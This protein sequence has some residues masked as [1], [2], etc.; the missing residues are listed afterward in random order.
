LLLD[1]LYF[2]EREFGGPAYDPEARKIYEKFSPSNFVQNWKTP[3]LVIHGRKRD[4]HGQIMFFVLT[5]CH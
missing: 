3:T 1:E 5:V 2:P 4:A